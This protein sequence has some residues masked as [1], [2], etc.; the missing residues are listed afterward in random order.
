MFT[1]AEFKYLTTDEIK[2]SL[3]FLFKYERIYFRF[4]GCSNRGG[5]WLARVAWGVSISC[6][7]L[8]A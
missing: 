8:Q 2:F 5:E 4:N 3:L 7:A 1:E 6:P